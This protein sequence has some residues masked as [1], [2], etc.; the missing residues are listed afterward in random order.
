MIWVVLFFAQAAA[1]TQIERGE[2]I[3]QDANNGCVMC[4]ALKG[5]GTAVGPDLRGIA[6]LTPKGIAM[7]VHSTVTQY[8]QMA[9]LKSGVTFPAMTVPGS[10][11]Q[12]VQLYDLSKTPPELLKVPKSDVASMTPNSVW[13]HPPAARKYTNEQMADIVAYI[14]FAGANNR[15][16]VDPGDVQ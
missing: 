1:P 4:H 15:Q 12:T 7:A 3:F 11:D 13:K 8:V 14:R 5:K 9:K 2:A 6:R 10:D 16:P